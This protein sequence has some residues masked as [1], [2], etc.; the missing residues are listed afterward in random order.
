MPI[1]EQAGFIDAEGKISQEGVR[2]VQG[3]SLAA[4]YGDAALVADIIES[5]DTNIKAIGSAQ[6][7][8]SADWAAMRAEATAGRINPV[9]DITADLVAA[10]Q[11]VRRARDEGRNV[12]EFVGQGDMF[13][14]RAVSPLT[15]GVLRVFFRG[16]QFDRPR[17]REK[18]TSGLRFYV[19]EA[20]KT[21]PDRDVFGV[22]RRARHRYWRM[23]M[24]DLN[25]KQYPAAIAW[26]L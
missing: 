12:A 14:G 10:A 25:G 7:D 8:V 4:A 11:I 19:E 1:S 24:D 26:S 18:I 15:E 5:A 16:E 2:R 17:G 22:S 3:A 6:L 21:T 9:I 13:S 23:S 20:R